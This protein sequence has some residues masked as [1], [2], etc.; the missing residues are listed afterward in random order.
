[1]GRYDAITGLYYLQARYYDPDL[2]HFLTLDPDEGDEEESI[3][4]NGYA[5]A[6]NNPVMLADPDGE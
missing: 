5:Y 3:T 1:V 6:N 2:G 4:Q